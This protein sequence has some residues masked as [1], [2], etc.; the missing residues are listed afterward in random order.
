MTAGA[1]RVELPPRR[2]ALRARL[3]F[4]DPYNGADINLYVTAGIDP[5]TGR[6]AE[7]FLRP[8]GKMGKNSLLERTLDDAAMTLSHCLRRGM[9][10]AELAEA[11]GCARA[12]VGG[13]GPSSPVAAAVVEAMR[14]Q[15]EIDRWPQGAAALRAG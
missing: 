9:S 10:L 14:M 3:E 7:L 4:R 5:A 12:D 1:R 13:A 2:Q 6:I 8:G 15:E 11:M